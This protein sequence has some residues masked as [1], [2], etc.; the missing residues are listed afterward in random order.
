[1]STDG[2]VPAPG[3]TVLAA[4]DGPRSD[5]AGSRPAAP[6]SGRRVVVQVVAAIVGVLL[7]VGLAGVTVVRR[8]AER[9]AVNDAAQQTDLLAVSVIMP[10]L[11]EALA[12]GD[13]AARAAFDEVVRGRVLG[14]RF[15]RVKVWSPTGTVLYSDATALVGARFTLDEG[16]RA[17]L[18]APAT[19]AE[20]SDLGRPENVHE[21]GQGRL[22]EVYRPVWTPSGRPLL[23]ET[24]TRYG[25]VTSRTGDLWRGFGGIVISS[26]LLFLVLLLPL[27]WTLLDRQR[28]ALAQRE[29][30]LR[31]AVDASEEER[32]RI[33]ADLHDGVV[34]ELVAA[35][36]AVAVAAERPAAGTATAAGTTAGTAGLRDSAAA[37]RAAVA[38]LRTLLVDIYPPTLRTAGV[39]GALEDLAAQVRVRGPEVVVEVD[40]EVA[41][42]LPDGTQRLVYRIARETL[43]NAAKH[44]GAA[45]V[46]VT[47]GRHGDGVRLEVRDDGA[48]FVPDRAAVDARPGH[49]GLRLLADLAAEHGARLAVSSAPGAGCRWRLDVDAPGGPA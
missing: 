14:D 10:A 20:V 8:I 34:Q 13:A 16:A 33:A 22:L 15:V 44:S 21:R 24:Y 45:R 39:A 17:V 31:L 48:G 42:A 43:R 38:G 18:S 37:V 19:V 6:V 23:F 47:L 36:L 11:P 3:W 25:T 26:L 41:D 28:R 4:G 12:D 49:L 46:T 30:L 5:R 35:S 2:G 1:M 29:H 7:V 9:E 27:L 40:R 32:R